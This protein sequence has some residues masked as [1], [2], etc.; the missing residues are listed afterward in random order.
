MPHSYQLY[1]KCVSSPARS[2]QKTEVIYATLNV[3]HMQWL[4]V[5]E[6]RLSW[7]LGLGFDRV[8]TETEPTALAGAGLRKGCQRKTDHSSGASIRNVPELELCPSAC[9]DDSFLTEPCSVQCYVAHSLCW[10][11]HKLGSQA[12]VVAYF[13][14]QVH[15]GHCSCHYNFIW[16][17]MSVEQP[18]AMVFSSRNYLSSDVSK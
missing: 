13:L 5:F 6:L 8:R 10:L 14:Y 18:C 1:V 9:A 4:Q 2:L 12:G 7:R 17:G 3:K 16:A 11:A 15:G